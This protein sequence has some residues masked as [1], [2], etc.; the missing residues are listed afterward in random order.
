MKRSEFKIE[1]MDCPSEESLI[2][3]K[4]S[5][6]KGIQSLNF[7]LKDRTLSIDHLSDDKQLSTL[8]A[9]LNLESRL[10][11]TIDISNDETMPLQ[12]TERKSLVIVLL[13][14]FFLFVVEFTTGIISESIGLIADSLDM[15]A[16]V[17]VYGLSL[18]VVGGHL[19]AK[20]RVAKVSGYLQLL[21]AVAGFSEVIRR[22]FGAGEIP[23]FETMVY[24]SLLALIGNA[25][26][27]Y[28]LQKQKSKEVHMQASIIFTSNDVI[29]NVGVI[30]AAV[31]VYY[32]NSAIPDLIIGAIVFFLV[33]RGAI[34]ILK[35]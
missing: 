17:I 2:R 26:S 12:K 5:G 25:L 1:K 29:V 14:N 33:T 6:V 30:I 11:Q 7:N 28:I 21:L 13:I 23:H 24:I 15:F 34:R 4:L 18:L 20:R 8:L 10:L 31:L 9:S 22:F 16:D 3:M 19:I 35:L 32:L 27:L